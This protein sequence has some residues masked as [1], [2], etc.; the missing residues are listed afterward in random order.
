MSFVPCVV[1]I[2]WAKD[3]FSGELYIVQAR[4]ETVFGS[5]TS[6]AHA[7]LDVYELKGERTEALVHGRSVGWRIGSGPARVI[8]NPA[9]MRQ[10][11]VGSQFSY[12]RRSA[13]R[14]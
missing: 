14:I 4:R 10:L 2:E 9:D 8:L 11:K 5:V 13:A 12:W 1:D 7:A 3:G 6:T